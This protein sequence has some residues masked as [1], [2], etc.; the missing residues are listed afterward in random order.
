MP[1]WWGTVLY[2]TAL[3]GLFLGLQGLLSTLG[4]P[5][6]HQASLAALPAVAVLLWSLPLRLRL[7][8]GESRPWRR[9]GVIAPW[10]Q[11]ITALGSGLGA[12][13]LLLLV[14]LVALRFSGALQW[15]WALSPGLALNALALGLGVGFAEE[16]L[17]R[18]WLLG[19][20]TLLIGPHRALLLQAALF[21]VVH[22]RFHLP[23]PLLLL[24][25]GGLLL[26]GLALGLQR[27][28]NGGVLWGAVGLHGGLV[29]G[30]FS[31][32]QGILV[33]PQSGPAWL[34][35]PEN[36][37]GGVVGWCGL[38]MLLAWLQRR[39]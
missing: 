1:S 38:L 5:L 37:I 24:L 30:W 19:E 22:T 33:L 27:R 17:F 25:L 36:P 26:L 2:P 16:L 11:C 28:C 6:Q 23:P 8:W 12:A 3:V 14:E 34:L 4:V 29:A 13:F 20:L 39:S 21:S 10:P 35:S 31:L 9:L 32:S 15:R 7:A 18:G